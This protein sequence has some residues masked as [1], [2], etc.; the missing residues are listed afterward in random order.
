MSSASILTPSEA[1]RGRTL[2]YV[3]EWFIRSALFLCAMVSIATTVGIVWVLIAESVSFFRVVPVFDF[4]T[5]TRW[6]PLIEPKSFG[7]LPLICGTSLVAGGALLVAVPIG[8]ASAL[9]MSEFSP[10]G[11]RNVLKPMLEILAGIPTVVY[12]YFALTFITP[13][14]LQPLFQSTEIFNA[15]SAAIVVGIMI[16]PTIASLGDDALRAVPRTLRE[17]AYAL[18]ATKLEVSTR[19]VF[20]AAASGIVASILL[21]LGR[22]IGETMA[23]AIAAGA[24]PRLSLNPLKSIETLTAFIVEVAGGDTPAGGV[25]YQTIFAV[26]LTLFVITLSINFIARAVLNRFKESY[27]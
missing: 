23:V 26:G 13:K 15:A 9:F 3:R 25:E 14:I 21:A 11:L 6:A 19:V 2:L 20:P 17:A 16:I 27:E 4:L 7:V 22:A 8:L 1:A 5:G 10:A 18:S 24:M 12:G